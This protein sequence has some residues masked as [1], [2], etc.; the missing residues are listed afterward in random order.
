MKNNRGSLKST[1][2]RVGFTLIELL[3]VIAIIAILAALLLPALSSAKQKGQG[4]SCMNNHRQLCYAWRMYAEDSGDILVYA[5]TSSGASSP[6]NC[7]C[8]DDFAWS[9]AHMDGNGANRANWDPS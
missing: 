7:S 6:P 5:S 4:I 9:G 8:P 3:V 1:I 2:R